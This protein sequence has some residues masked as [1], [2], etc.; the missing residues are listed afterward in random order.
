MNDDLIRTLGYS[1]LDARLKRISDKM[2]HSTRAMYKQLNIDWEPN[3]YLVLILVRDTP[4]ISVMEIANRLKFTHQS[5]DIM[6]KKM[7]NKGYL[8]HSKDKDDK[9]KT[10]FQLTQK[11]K[12]RLPILTKIWNRGTEVIFE[13]MNEDTAIIKHLEVLESNL[14]KS[15]FGERIIQKLND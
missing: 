14:E 9:R 7:V 4:N 8:T 10:V 15:S 3:W 11:A 1:N 6:A 12:D 5:I 13:L 2:T